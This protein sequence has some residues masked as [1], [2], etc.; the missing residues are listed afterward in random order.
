MNT[1]RIQI[2]AAESEK[3]AIQR[4]CRENDTDVTNFLLDLAARE[5]G[6]ERVERP[7]GA[8]KG[9]A[10]VKDVTRE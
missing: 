3:D 1:Q 6:F 8:P 9:N 2:K 10:E 7:E 4:H 5:I